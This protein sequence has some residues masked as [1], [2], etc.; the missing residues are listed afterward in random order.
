MNKSENSRSENSSCNILLCNVSKFYRDILGVNRINLEIGVGITGLVGPNGAGKSTLMNLISGLISPTRG[1]IQ[2]L[3]ITSSEPELY[4]RQLG[5]CAQYDSFPAG[6]NGYEFLFNT[7]RIHGYDRSMSRELTFQTLDQVSLIKA[8]NQ[9][10]ST[11]SKGMRQRIKL[12]QA[13]CHRPKILILDEP[14]N[15]LDPLARAQVIRLL[16]DFAETGKIVLISSQILHEVDLVSDRV[17]LINGG[18]LI[19]E[20]GLAK[21]QSETGEPLKIFIRSCEASDIA[22]KLFDLADVVEVQLHHDS[23]G[24]FIRSRDADAFYLAF[25]RKI[26]KESWSIDSMGPA[27]ET[28]EAIYQHLIVDKQV[29]T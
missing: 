16:Q 22:A 15:G 26:I 3:G 17:V 21:I 28:V 23:C 6:V 7:L 2:A 9:A 20:G 13:I 14:L 8:A 10:I 11:Y 19:A 24:L 29:A 5:Y 1:S 18:Y 12:A 4:F 27:D 25:N